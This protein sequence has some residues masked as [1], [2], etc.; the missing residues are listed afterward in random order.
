MTDLLQPSLDQLCE[1]APTTESTFIP[2]DL[3]YVVYSRHSSLSLFFAL[4]TFTPL[5]VFIALATLVLFRRELEAANQCLGL[6]LSTALNHALKRLLAHPRPLH[7]SKEGHGMPSDHAQFMAF[8]LAYTSC[9]LF[10]RACVRGYMR[11]LMVAALTLAT[12]LV[13]VS[14]VDLGVHSAEQVGVGLLVGL[15]TGYGYH[16]LSRLCLWP[17][18]DWVLG[19]AVMRWLCMKDMSVVPDVMEFEWESWR[20]YKEWI[21]LR[22]RQKGGKAKRVGEEV[23]D[24]R[25][26]GQ[27]IAEAAASSILHRVHANGSKKKGR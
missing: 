27:G 20:A 4:V 26:D 3:T 1:R 18:Y 8:Y 15:A 7:S 9:W 21:E 11:H 16:V 2:L 13:A 6:L 19:W 5:V 12:A 23:E 22:E 14:R 24:L 25:A 10:H 17:W